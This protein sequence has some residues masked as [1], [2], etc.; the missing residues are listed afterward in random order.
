MLSAPRPDA[1]ADSLE[2][3][4]DDR[5][6]AAAMARRARAFAEEHT[7]ERAGDQV[8]EALRA[9]MASPSRSTASLA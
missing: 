2:R 1:I 9:F 6:Q 5:E 8:E 3:I 4:L 7:W